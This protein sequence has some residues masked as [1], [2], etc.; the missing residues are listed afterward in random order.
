MQVA[1]AARVRPIAMSQEVQALAELQVR[2]PIMTLQDSQVN[3]E[4]SA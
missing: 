1:L 2:H 3:R 4:G